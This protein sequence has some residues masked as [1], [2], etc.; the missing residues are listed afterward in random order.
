MTMTVSAEQQL[1]FEAKDA[2]EFRELLGR[3]LESSPLSCGQIAI[4]TGMPR[5]TAYS[6]PNTN[7]PGLPSNPEQVIAFV[8]ACGLTPTQA[9]LVMDLWTKLQHEAENT[10]A[11][12][13]DKEN[14]RAASAPKRAD[15]HRFL[16]LTPPCN[17]DQW[18]ESLAEMFGRDGN[19][20]SWNLRTTFPGSWPRRTSGADLLQ[21][22]LGDA[23]R[24][25]RAV[26]LLI[27]VT[28]LLL[29]VV[30]ALVVL[31]VIK[32]MVAPIVVAGLLTPF[33]LTARK[34]F[35]KPTAKAGD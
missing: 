3:I 13:D 20:N 7:R 29:A 32:P 2:T 11:V 24:T 22:V 17:G 4:K 21:Y 25:R 30:A 10:R 28:L 26:L 16:L 6:L 9:Q 33:L 23:E 27:P 5:S 15:E 14:S 19:V 35:R 12:D 31:A 18:P 8:R 1:V 34:S